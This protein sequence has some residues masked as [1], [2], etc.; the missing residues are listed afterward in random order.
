MP[1][2]A[3]NQLQA[4]PLPI[5]VAGGVVP[6]LPPV[7]DPRTTLITE[8]PTAIAQ[9]P[10][11]TGGPTIEATAGQ[12]QPAP[13]APAAQPAPADDGMTPLV[14]EEPQAK[15]RRLAT[16]QPALK[17]GKPKAKPKTG[18]PKAKAK[19][20]KPKAKPKT[21]K[22]KAKAKTV[23]K[24]TTKQGLKHTA[25]TTKR[26]PLPSQPVARKFRPIHF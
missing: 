26:S 14:D 18:K 17:T 1:D 20:V 10:V 2:L 22:P 6:P 4:T 9:P 5:T 15:R 13:A 21:G 24:G 25:T 8:A 23:L 19:T 12:A 16:R 3:L 7:P 11:A